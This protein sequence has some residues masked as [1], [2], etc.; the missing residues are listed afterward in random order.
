MYINNGLTK[1]LLKIR[2]YTYMQAIVF[3]TYKKYI[4]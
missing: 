4:T 1:L 3:Q 2:F